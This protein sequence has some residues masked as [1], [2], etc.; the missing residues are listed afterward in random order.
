VTTR[1]AERCTNDEDRDVALSIRSCTPICCGRVT[2]TGRSAALRGNA[3]GQTAGASEVLRQIVEAARQGD[4]GA[5]GELFDRYH[6]VLYRYAVARLGTPADAE[7]AVAET[8]LAALKALPRFRWQGVPFEAWLF[9]IAASKVVDLGRRRQRAAV[10][11]D[12]AGL[13]PMDESADPGDRIDRAEQ[14]AELAAALD[15]LPATQR[16][17]LVL[18][19]LLGHSVQ[20]VAW[21]LGRTEGAV[22]QLQV[23]ALANVRKR[24]RA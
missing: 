23:R 16:D 9:R 18:R 22:K 15:A 11:I 20:E 17:V 1:P 12:A 4:P 3:A 19:F 2:S 6:A 24:V 5:R 7:D 10:P 13:D 14:Q 8:F 21:A